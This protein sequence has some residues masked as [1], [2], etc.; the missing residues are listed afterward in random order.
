MNVIQVMPPPAMPRETVGDW[1]GIERELSVLPFD[2][3]ELIRAYGTGCFDDFIWLL[4]PFSEQRHL[5][6]LVQAKLA[7]GAHESLLNEFHEPQP[8]A[9]F[10]EE[11]GLLPFAITDNGDY[12]NWETKGPSE[13]W[14]V[15][16]SA[17][18]E[19]KYE[20]FDCSASEF[21]GGLFG[22]LLT[23]R[24]FPTDFPSD[25]PSFRRYD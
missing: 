20:V 25:N 24:I 16:V 15:V 23:C 22:R 8:Y 5:N 19:P 21:L 11:A 4:N 18:R 3:K 10:P 13:T 9:F 1:L 6:L 7:R 2:Y 12:L 14:R 17:G